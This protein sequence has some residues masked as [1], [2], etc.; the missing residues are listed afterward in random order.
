LSVYCFSFIRILIVFIQ[1]CKLE[2][3]LE[4]KRTRSF[5]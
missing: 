5:C 3:E 4:L 1:G 2:L